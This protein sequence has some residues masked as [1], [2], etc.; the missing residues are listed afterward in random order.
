ME[1][2]LEYAHIYV[3]LGIFFTAG[4]VFYKIRSSHKE[5]QFKEEVKTKKQ[6]KSFEG[7]IDKLIDEAPETQQQ[8]LKLREE[9]VRDGATPDQLKALDSKIQLLGYAASYGEIAKPLIK[10]LG[11]ILS[12]LTGGR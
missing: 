1:Q 5:R 9:M 10:P 12:K 8:L 4:I 6:A 11:G 3:F 2:L 7:S